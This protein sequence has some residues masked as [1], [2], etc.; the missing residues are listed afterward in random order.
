M[1]EWHVWWNLYAT[2]VVAAVAVVQ[3]EVNPAWQVMGPVNIV[4][5]LPKENILIRVILVQ[6]SVNI[7]ILRGE[8]IQKS[9]RSASEVSI[10]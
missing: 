8:S 2:A 4:V 7:E 9:T 3:A 5:T 10:I 6:M 1:Q